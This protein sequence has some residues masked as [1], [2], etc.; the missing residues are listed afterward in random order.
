VQFREWRILMVSV[1][2]LVLNMLLLSW[3]YTIHYDQ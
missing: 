1:V 2:I 3:L